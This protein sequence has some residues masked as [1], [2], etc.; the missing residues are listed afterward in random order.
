MVEVDMDGDGH[1]R[2]AE[3]AADFGKERRLIGLDCEGIA[4]G[5]LDDGPGPGGGIAGVGVDGDETAVE[6]EAI[7]ASHETFL[8][9]CAHPMPSPANLTSVPRTA[10]RGP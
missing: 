5:V 8:S 2:M 7:E 10:D 4:A 6:V 3:M 9:R 1:G